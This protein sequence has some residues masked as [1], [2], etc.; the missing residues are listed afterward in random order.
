LSDGQDAPDDLSALSDVVLAWA[1]RVA[2]TLR[3][4]DHIA[5]GHTRLH[6]LAHRAGADPD[7]LGRLL[8][9]LARRGIFWE[10]SLGRF[11]LTEAALVLKDDHPSGAREFL[12]LDGIGSRLIGAWAGLLET[13]RTGRPGYAVV[14]GRPF[15][16]DIA[17]DPQLSASFDAL[18]GA[19]HAEQH[20]AV[21][22]AYPWDRTPRVVDVGGGTG[23]LLIEILRTH[24]G[25]RGTLVDLPGPA[26]GA[27][28]AFA[29]AGLADRTE[30]VAQ[31]FFDPLP[32]GG[33]AYVVS[34][35]I[36]DWP[37][38]EATAILRRCAEA[39]APARRVIVV[40]EGIDDDRIST[41]ADLLM[42]V[43]VGGRGRTLAELRALAE[44]A[45]LSVEAV[46]DTTAGRR[47][48]EC[49]A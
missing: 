22:V 48:V 14:F 44:A 24:R 5:A 23:A 29:T 4:A 28:E 34:S 8:R 18:L 25:V 10:P 32:R 47:I 37:D 1:V 46:H 17:A 45:G 7:A 26:A 15:W 39:A 2:A 43:L 35:V 49:V 41:E 38:R 6:D 42:L 33:D 19:G 40:G 16:E 12:D 36:D 9:Y 30:V 31:S 21:A 27:R 13:V 11:A 3:V 20:A